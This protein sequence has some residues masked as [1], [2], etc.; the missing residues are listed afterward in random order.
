M[1]GTSR[2]S[3]TVRFV[4]YAVV[5]SAFVITF[6][7]LLWLDIGSQVATSVAAG[8]PPVA[9]S[10]QGFLHAPAGDPS[11]PRASDALSPSADVEPEAAPTF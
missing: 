11:V 8:Q 4:W 6:A 9:A 1:T 10:P 3:R 7:G 5:P 2:N